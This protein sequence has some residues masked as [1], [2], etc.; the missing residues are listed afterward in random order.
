MRT[1]WICIRY[2]F[3]WVEE[4]N[5]QTYKQKKDWGQF[6]WLISIVCEMSFEVCFYIFAPRSWETVFSFIFLYK[7]IEEALRQGTDKPGNRDYSLS[8]FTKTIIKPLKPTQCI[9]GVPQTPLVAPP[10]GSVWHLTVKTELLQSVQWSTTCL[11]SKKERWE[12]R[13][14]KT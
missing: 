1:Q 8:Y 5:K 3:N 13:G 6:F 10:S 14:G 9:D 7:Y 4:T 11:V 2:L 12:R